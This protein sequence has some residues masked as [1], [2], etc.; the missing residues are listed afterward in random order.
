M[1]CPINRYGVIDGEQHEQHENR[2]DSKGY[3]EDG[4]DAG[5]YQHAEDIDDVPLRVEVEERGRRPGGD[6]RP[7][8]GGTGHAEREG[9]KRAEDVE[10]RHEYGKAD[11]EGDEAPSSHPDQEEQYQ[12]EDEQH[13]YEDQGICNRLRVFERHKPRRLHG[14]DE[15]DSDDLDGEKHEG[16][17]KK[18]QPVAYL[19][20]KNSIH[21][22]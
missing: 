6:D 12:R 19:H 11:E 1:F 7:D 15:D 14:H 20:H 21:F 9:G 13:P 22:R 17:P 3:P 16:H 10:E 5:R 4:R 8:G 18:R 2:Q